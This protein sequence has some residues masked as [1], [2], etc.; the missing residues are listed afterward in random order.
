MRLDPG[1][2]ALPG[3]AIVTRTTIMLPDEVRQRAMA[4]ARKLKAS[5]ADFVRQAIAEKLP[6]SGGGGDRLKRRRED[7]LFRRLAALA[8]QAGETMNEFLRKSIRDR[9]AQIGRGLKSPLAEFFG[10]VDVTVPP[11]TN[12]GVRRAMRGRR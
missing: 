11:P 1:S 3:Y 2:A 4:E 12:E 9:V 5:F 10:S 7:S 8:E 6:H